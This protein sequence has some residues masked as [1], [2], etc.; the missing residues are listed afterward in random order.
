MS[1]SLLGVFDPT[2]D[3]RKRTGNV[4]PSRLRMPH[5]RPPCACTS[6][7]EPNGP[8]P[9]ATTKPAHVRH[10][11]GNCT[12]VENCLGDGIK[13]VVALGR[14]CRGRQ[15]APRSP[16][17]QRLQPLPPRVYPTEGSAPEAL[18][19]T[20]GPDTQQKV[21]RRDGSSIITNEGPCSNLRARL[22]AGACRPVVASSWNETRANE[23]GRKGRLYIVSAGATIVDVVHGTAGRVEEDPLSVPALRSATAIMQE[24]R[25]RGG[26]SRTPEQTS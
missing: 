21:S 3:T 6:G 26:T 8:S 18:T 5:V 9:H 13:G 12:I 22:V 25:E 11:I 15:D 17:L 10:S 7:A 20:Q 23:R 2:E 19:G 24:H 14:I 4:A 1:P 16:W